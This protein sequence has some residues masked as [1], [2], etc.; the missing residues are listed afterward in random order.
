MLELFETQTRRDALPLLGLRHVDR[1][2]GRLLV[3]SSA[4]ATT[5]HPRGLQPLSPGLETHC[6]QS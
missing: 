1:Q 5:Q 4:L 3:A 6:D 2:S